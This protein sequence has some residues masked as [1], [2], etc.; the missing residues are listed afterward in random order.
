MAE[1]ALY[2]QHHQQ[3]ENN[4]R[5]G[6]FNRSDYFLRVL[7]RREN[8]WLNVKECLAFKCLEQESVTVMVTE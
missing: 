4:A 1:I 7:N 2:I 8:I 5:S 3:E 6:Q